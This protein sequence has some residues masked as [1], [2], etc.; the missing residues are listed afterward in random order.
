MNIQQK[1]TK[2]GKFYGLPENWLESHPHLFASSV[3]HIPP[4]QLQAMQNIIQAVEQVVHLPAYAT[5]VLTW[6]E[7]AYAKSKALG[8]FIGYDFHLTSEGPKLIEINTNPAGFALNA[9]LALGNNTWEDV[10]MSIFEA[11]WQR[12]R[13]NGTLQRIAIVDDQ[14]QQ[15]YFYPEFLLFQKLLHDYGIDSIIVDP[16]E[17]SIKN[18]CLQARGLGIDLVYNRLTD[19]TLTTPEHALLKAA[20]LEDFVVLTPNPYVYSLYANKKNLTLLSDPDF[21]QNCEVQESVIAEL[22]QGIA[23]TWLVDA[24]QADWFWQKRKEL[25]FK[26]ATS[27]AGKGVYQGSKVTHKVFAEILKNPYVAQTFIPPSQQRGLKMDVRSYAY[28][29]QVLGVA[30]RLYQGQT[31]NFRSAGSGFA[32]V[33]VNI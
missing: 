20:Y 2:L 10:C 24:K 8:L 21:L 28:A 32:V 1:L 22:T 17:L 18:N 5:Q 26:P 25:F 3:V 4:A 23:K 12:C 15:Q 9:L 27:Y 16:A 6:A 33:N 11:E 30:A 19:F 31:T 29:G 13:E 14:P 7:Q